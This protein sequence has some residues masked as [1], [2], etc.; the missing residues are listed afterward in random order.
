M[1]IRSYALVKSTVFPRESRT[2]AR[3]L[4]EKLQ[5]RATVVHAIGRG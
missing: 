3:E 5:V 1:P 2:M 4:G